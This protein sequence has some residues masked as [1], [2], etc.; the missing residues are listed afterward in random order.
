MNPHPHQ[1]VATE[2]EEPRRVVTRSQARGLL[3]GLHQ[4]LTTVCTPSASTGG[5]EAITLIARLE[6]S[7]CS[8]EKEDSG[9]REGKGSE[10]VNQKKASRE[11][12]SREGGKA[13]VLDSKITSRE[14]TLTCSRELV[15]DAPDLDIGSRE[16]S[17]AG[18]LSFG[19][20]ED[21]SSR[22]PSTDS[23][24]IGNSPL[25]LN[26]SR[27]DGSPCAGK[28]LARELTRELN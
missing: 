28:W 27:E 15:F 22:Y 5:G 1:D 13:G 17:G 14:Q 18:N 11:I 12:V 8:R 6:G 9:S 20:R 4:G 26:G 25:L 3:Q 16:C 19:S 21:R 2:E 7:G 10:E 24:E 23:R